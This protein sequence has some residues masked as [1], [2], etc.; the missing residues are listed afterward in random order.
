ML[1]YMFTGKEV[2]VKIKPHGNSKS[3]TPFLRTSQKTKNRIRTL[4]ASATPKEVIQKVT[5][6]EGGELG[7]KGIAFLPRNRQQVANFR[8]SVQDTRDDNVLYSVMLQCKL[9]QGKNEIFVQDVKAAPEPQSVLF[10]DWQ[11]NDLIRFCTNNH[12]FSIL[13]VDTTFNLGDFF[14]T[15]MSYCHLL[16]DDVKSGKHPVMI[17]PI[18]V[19]QST[20][21]SAYNYFAS[22]LIG[23][24]KKLRKVMA[25][26]TDGDNSLVEALAHNFPFAIQLRCFIHFKKNLEI[27][28]RDLAIPQRVSQQFMA[29]IF[30][31]QDGNVR[32]EGLVDC[33]SIDEFD[34][35]LKALE[36]PWNALES[37]HA[38]EAGPKFY[39]YFKRVH[40]DVVRHHMRKDL[41]EV[42]GLGS[43]PAIFTTNNAEAINSVIKKQV[44]YKSNQWPE[45]VEQMKS[46]IEAQ[47]SEIIR[48]LSG[49]GYYRL[50]EGYQHLAVSIDE[51]SKM[52]TDQRKKVLDKFASEQS[53]AVATLPSSNT[54]SKPR[55]VKI[56]DQFTSCDTESEACSSILPSYSE[57]SPTTYTSTENRTE[58]SSCLGVSVEESGITTLP[59]ITLRGLWSKASALLQGDNLITP[60]PGSDT[61]SRAVISYHS[62]VPHIVT[63]RNHC[64]FLCDSNC[65]QWVSSKICSHT[66]A[67]AQANNSLKEFLQWY[68]SSSFQPN[69]TSLAM[70]GMPTGRGKK[71]NQIIKS[72]SRKKV[73]AASP[74]AFVASPATLSSCK[75]NTC[76]PGKANIPSCG[77]CHK[78]SNST[79][80]TTSPVIL[81]HGSNNASF[82]QQ[83]PTILSSGVR[84]STC[85]SMPTHAEIS[86]P[87]NCN[88]FYLKFITGN[89]RICQGC[90]S[91]LRLADGTVPP[92]PH[93]LTIARAERRPYRDSS[94]ILCI[95]KKETVSH[96]HCRLICVKTADPSFV[97]SSLRVP[98]D[99]YHQLT[100]IHREYLNG[101][102]GLSV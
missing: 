43:P 39:N 94:G 92:P 13:T 58:S 23:Y 77:V 14:V 25:Y 99:I 75:T 80:Q 78:A 60:T 33:C 61:R 89:I 12:L 97:P 74:D 51:W 90:R 4:A 98:A 68:V 63:C 47:H 87:A 70:S 11:A 15:P 32:Y 24:D 62:K 48:S 21:F 102:F 44:K 45:F 56:H 16:L 35:K 22:T 30:G 19:H 85:P 17:G 37:P 66:V 7:A 28:L 67:V 86:L 96:Y 2:E 52:R 50:T 3:R 42:A 8:H 82:V 83:Q 64:Q 27:K 18:L 34:L 100:A 84:C 101:Q 20:K 10:F 65:P 6:E 29:D 41:R 5:T 73:S 55:P 79:P 72:T 71:K 49:R 26:G 46:L 54:K 59:L 69:I 40:A 91:S 36:E 1:Q 57:H 53:L 38:S 9:A 93:N 88:P 95:P 76:I 31:R 81:V